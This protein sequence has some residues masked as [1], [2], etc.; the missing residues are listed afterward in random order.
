MQAGTLQEVRAVLARYTARIGFG[1]FGFATK[2]ADGADGDRY[3]HF[4][5]FTGEWGES[6]NHL[7][8]PQA[9]REDPRILQARAWL[10]PAA[11]NSLGASNYRLPPGIQSAA[12][13]KLILAGEFGLHSGITIPLR[14]PGVD[15]SFVTLTAAHRCPPREHA[16]LLFSA[17][18]FAACLQ[19]SLQRLTR[20][21]TNANGT[22]TLREQECLRWSA[23]GKTSWD[24]SMIQ[25]ISERTVNFHLQRAAHKLGVKGRRAAVAQALARGLI[26]L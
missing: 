14:A 13:R 18:Y 22:L 7:H 23:L 10:P 25:K 8:T 17:S 19:V 24:I 20:L 15:W 6:Y 11:W 16:P 1:N 4:H 12:K 21:A 26:R 2:L 3:F 9:E 5:D